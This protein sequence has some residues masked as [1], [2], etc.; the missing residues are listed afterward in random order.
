MCLID[1]AEH[2]KLNQISR[3]A[4]LLLLVTNNRMPQDK[5]LQFY[6]DLK[7]SMNWV[8]KYH[9]VEYDNVLNV[10]VLNVNNVTKT[11]IRMLLVRISELEH[12]SPPAVEW[13]RRAFRLC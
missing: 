12:G 2:G 4:N 5:R 3:D 10:N 1:A 11:C 6:R 8:Y 7:A 13:K 9:T